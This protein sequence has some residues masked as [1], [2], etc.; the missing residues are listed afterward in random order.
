MY[1]SDRERVTSALAAVAIVALMV[2]ALVFGLRVVQRPGAAAA[3]ISM[4]LEPPPPEKKER[5]PKPRP[6]RA[7]APAPKDAPSP[8]NRRNKATPVVVPPP[9][10]VIAPP[11]PIVVATQAGK[12]AAA[13]S[14]AALRPGPG[15]GAGGIGNGL[16]GGGAG[17]NGDGI[18]DETGPRHIAGR[19][20]FS[21]M[22]E[23]L[24]GPG[25]SASVGVRYAVETSGRVSHCRIDRSS[26]KA[27]LDALVCRLIE[28]RFRFRPA[29]DAEGRPVRSTVV[30][31][32]NWSVEPE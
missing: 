3:L 30:E 28:K 4:R 17:G 2:W 19:L 22:P 18:G 31:T 16:G 20:R 21:D 25:E 14:G 5:Q 29:L 6:K 26:G 12:G 1:V 27:A 13:S 23:S 10:I 7:S 32:H 8:P 9:R 24:L 11:P 15:Q